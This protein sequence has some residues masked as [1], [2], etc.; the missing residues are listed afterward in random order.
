MNKIVH[1]LTRVTP[2]F[3]IFLCV[4]YS[5][6]LSAGFIQKY[7]IPILCYGCE[8]PRGISNHI[9]RC[10]MDTSP[11]SHL[12][13]VSNDMNHLKQN[14]TIFFNKIYKSAN[15]PPDVLNQLYSIYDDINGLISSV[16][17]NIEN[18]IKKI[19]EFI[20]KTIT[21]VQ[22]EILLDITLFQTKVID[23]VV[24]FI[25]DTIVKEF[26]ALQKSFK[27]LG[28]FITDARDAIYNTISNAFGPIY[29]LGINIDAL[30]I[31]WTPF[32]DIW[33]SITDP[34]D[35][36]FKKAMAPIDTAITTVET[37]IT[38]LTADLTD[39]LV[40]KFKDAYDQ[41]KIFITKTIP[42]DIENMYETV[43][44]SL[45]D[46][47]TNDIFNTIY[48]SLL[49]ITSEVEL[50]IPIF[51][52]IIIHIEDFYKEIKLQTKV[53]IDYLY[54]NSKYI[55]FYY[56]ANIVNFIPINISITAKLNIVYFIII[57][58]LYK[59]SYAIISSIYNYMYILI[60]MSTMIS[61]IAKTT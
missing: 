33:N 60:L 49:K 23:P 11:N 31:H 20:T 50:I 9:F 40:Q 44:K 39:V 21:D 18:I 46:L 35:K 8:V 61:L 14:V 45:I 48:K 13:E 19:N 22:N 52:D 47:F 2:I 27:D 28:Q 32:K 10:V 53:I 5:G 42:T 56:F 59:F 24:N 37:A 12:C 26:T 38:N 7:R 57:L 54:D 16:T 29:A 15:L 3:L 4:V 36:A 6:L 58:L 41:I 17:Q 1:A 30:N 25:N 51:N 34:I 43:K 55:V